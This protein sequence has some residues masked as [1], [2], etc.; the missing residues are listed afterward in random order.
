M[1]VTVMQLSH[2]LASVAALECNIS[3]MGFVHVDFALLPKV[4]S[5][6]QILHIQSPFK[7]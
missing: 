1:S 7:I 5:T 4:Y 2:L 3:A 6:K